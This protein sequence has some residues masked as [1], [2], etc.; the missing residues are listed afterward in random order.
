[1]HAAIAD[2]DSHLVRY[3]EGTVGCRAWFP[4]FEIPA[5]SPSPARDTPSLGGG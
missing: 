2:V 5:E 1:M 3:G 4:F